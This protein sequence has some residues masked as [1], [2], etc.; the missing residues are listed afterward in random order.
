M[1]P[2]ASASSPDRP[3]A[4]DQLMEEARRLGPANRDEIVTRLYQTSQQICEEAVTYSQEKL[5]KEQRRSEKIDQILTSPLWGFPIMLAMLGVVIYLTVAGANIP[6]EMLARLF[7]MGEEAL[8]RLF[9]LIG[10]PEWLHGLLVLGL[11]RGISWVVSVMLPPMAIFF[12]MFALLENLGYLPRVAFN[13]DRLFKRAG[14]HGK[15]SLTMAMGFGCNAA[16]I[17][18]TRIIESPRERM[19]AILTNNFVPCNGRWPLLILLASLF[20]AAG[21]GGFETIVT[22]GIV[23]GMVLFGIVVTLLVSWILSKTLLRGVPT[24]YTLELPPYRMPKFWKTVIR[25]SLDKTWFVLKRAVIVAAPAGLL[26]WVLAN[27]TVG[28]DSLLE[29]AAQFLNPFGQ[30]LG[31]D[32]Y[33]LMAFLLG[34]PANEIVLPILLMSY[35]STGAMVDADGMNGLKQILV[36]HGWTWLTALNMMLFSLLHYPCGTTMFTIYRETKSPKWTALAFLIPT[37]IAILVTFTVTQV[38]RGLGLV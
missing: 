35:L 28:D 1:S 25:A 12:P 32:G 8:T 38:A 7:G 20:M 4:F 21:F 23:V 33:I 3:Q 27:I 24:H 15:Q 26:T 9:A 37:S 13:L 29:H 22:A 17:V 2:Y 10:A 34:L 31:M 36:D 11:Y 14:G 6:S 16:A 19:L 5:L 18:S 30:A